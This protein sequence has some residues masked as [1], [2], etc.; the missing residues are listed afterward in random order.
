VLWHILALFWVTEYAPKAGRGHVPHCLS[1]G[2]ASG[3]AHFQVWIATKWLEIDQSNSRA[4]FS[5]L[6]V[7]FSNFN[8]GPLCLR[9]F[10][11]G[12]VKYVYPFK[13][14]DFCQ[15]LLIWRVNGCRYRCV[16][17]GRYWNN[18]VPRTC[19]FFAFTY[20]EPNNLVKSTQEMNYLASTSKS[21]NV[22]WK[23]I[24]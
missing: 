13:M 6:N 2:Y 5:A 4:K 17:V 21:F 23:P 3:G 24:R 7:D 22:I 19:S 11:Y 20:L 10:A 15:Y 12:G 14:R 9:S 8:F 1:Y 16:I 18:G